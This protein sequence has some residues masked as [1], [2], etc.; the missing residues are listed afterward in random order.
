MPDHKV[1]CC[2]RG[3]ADPDEQAAAHS[4][5][6]SAAAVPGRRRE[7]NRNDVFAIEPLTAN[8]PDYTGTPRIRTRKAGD[9]N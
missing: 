1:S 9:D 7:R 8:E 5:T 4:E 2:A 3:A 6:S